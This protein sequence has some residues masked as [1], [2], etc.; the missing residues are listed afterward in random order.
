MTERERI[1]EQIA[2]AIGLQLDLDDSPELMD[3]ADAALRV[4]ETKPD[5]D[6]GIIG[7]CTCDNN[8]YDTIHRRGC[9]LYDSN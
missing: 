5:P 6:A 9:E 1:I 2:E 7:R 3:A 4:I 8:G